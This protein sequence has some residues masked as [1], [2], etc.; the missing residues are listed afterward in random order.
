M[1][2]LPLTSPV[3]AGT[4]PS[5]ELMN[6][7]RGLDENPQFFNAAFGLNPDSLSRV[8][9]AVANHFANQTRGQL[10]PVSMLVTTDDADHP[11]HADRETI[12]T[13]HVDLVA[14]GELP[15]IALAT[16]YP[17]EFTRFSAA[18]TERVG[19]VVER[20]L[21]GALARASDSVVE[22]DP[23]SAPSSAAEEEA[24]TRAPSLVFEGDPTSA[25]HSEEGDPRI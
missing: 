9:T 10:V 14:A 1:S 18:L 3:Y 23:T 21:A 2:L 20:Y 4:L 5:D 12:R 15:E 11:T 17:E 25:P 22:G 6:V 13:Q 16:A 24:L 8:S 7:F 19:E